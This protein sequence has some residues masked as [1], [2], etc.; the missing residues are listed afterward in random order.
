MH[1]RKG[2]C[3]D[4]ELHCAARITNQGPNI[5]PD[6]KAYKYKLL[7]AK[8]LLVF[9]TFTVQISVPQIRN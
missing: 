9:Q 2:S 7:C 1:F 4:I 3:Q 5:I 8:Q 6:R